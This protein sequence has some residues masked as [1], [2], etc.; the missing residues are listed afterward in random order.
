VVL[1]HPDKVTLEAQEAQLQQFT[2]VVVVA[3]LV[4]QEALV[5]EPEAAMAV[6]VLTLTLMQLGYL[7]HFQHQV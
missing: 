3:V 2:A 7:P 5:L 6:L 4:H 1:Q